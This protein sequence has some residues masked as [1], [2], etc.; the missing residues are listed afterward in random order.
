MEAQQLGPYVLIKR[1]GRGGMGAVY[2][3]EHQKTGEHVA[4]KVLA[5]HLADDLGL[6]E[7]FDAEIQTLKPL[8]SPG[9]V[10]LIAYGED[11][12]QP[13]FAMELVHGQSLERII[14]G[15]R[16]FTLEEVVGLSIE[17]ARSLKVAHD[18]GIIHRDL[19]PANLLVPDDPHQ[20][21]AGVKLADFGIAKLFGATSQTAHGSIVGTAEFMAPEQAAG[22]PLDARA[23]LY[24]LGLV[25]F[26]M[27]AGKPPFRGSQLTEIIT[28]QLREAPPRVSSFY[29]DIPEEL[30]GLIDGLLAKDPAKRPASALAVGRR[31]TAIR[32]LLTKLKE[33]LQDSN[34]DGPPSL[35]ITSEAESTAPTNHDRSSSLTK[36]TP[37]NKTPQASPSSIDLLAET[38]EGTHHVS[39][40]ALENGL[41]ATTELPRLAPEPPK[42]T[43][44]AEQNIEQPA[45]VPSAPGSYLPLE[46][47]PTKQAVSSA[48]N[49]TASDVNE[50]P[51][52]TVVD[53]QPARRFVT[54][55]EFDRAAHQKNLRHRWQ[56]IRID[57][58]VTAVTVLLVIGIAYWIIRPQT[59][60]EL[61]QTITLETQKAQPDLR[62]IRLEIDQFLTR[63]PGD[64]RAAV[65]G[66]LQQQ[67]RV[68][69]LE[70]KMR[71]RVLGSR[72]VPAIE[73]DY[74][75]ALAREPE[76]PS[77]ALLAMQAVRT[78]YAKHRYLSTEDFTAEDKQTWLSLIERQ[79]T[80][81][82][83]TAL[84]ERVE[85]LERAENVL[86]EASQ[87]YV[88]AIESLDPETAQRGI[89]QSRLLLQSVIETYGD[90]P[91]TTEIVT[92]AKDLLKTIDT[93]KTDNSITQ[94]QQ[95]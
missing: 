81:L 95:E 5:S 83:Q 4:V 77:A 22:K 84:K 6:K 89:G 52:S 12:G 51:N 88:E 40:N 78:V 94:G 82:E 38:K 8:R 49:R 19:K 50:D 75:A 71:R 26:T 46:R 57:T 20:A 39:S 62:R 74:R 66:S 30:D 21:N 33:P 35:I 15:G 44:S 9:I 29:H 67:L 60:D 10:Q 63:Y 2:E 61:F 79:I 93:A 73:R 85:D 43:P 13:Y 53:T 31:L 18:H 17:I 58:L 90:R 65:V 59:A 14:R 64:E 28:K 45:D 70:A 36:V 42:A 1:L 48:N 41:D 72:D 7:R 76:S 34:A 25:M 47:R 32:D 37:E 54:V 91:H 16:I 86:D 92:A 23:D 68:N 69:I 56:R 3:A 27:I 11:D 55:E 24:T 80:R 87:Q